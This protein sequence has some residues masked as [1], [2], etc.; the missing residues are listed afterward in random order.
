MLSYRPVED[1]HKE[2]P[3]T[4]PHYSASSQDI[5]NP[6]HVLAARLPLSAMLQQVGDVDLTLLPSPAGLTGR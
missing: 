6:R 1:L 3:S 4:R 5:L 2:A